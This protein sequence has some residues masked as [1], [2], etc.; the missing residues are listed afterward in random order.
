MELLPVLTICILLNYLS[1][2]HMPQ[3]RERK[4]MSI[5]MPSPYNVKNYPYIEHTKV[6]EMYFSVWKPWIEQCSEKR[7]EKDSQ[8]P[9]KFRHVT[10]GHAE[11]HQ[12]YPE[13]FSPTRRIRHSL[14]RAEPQV[15]ADTEWGGST[16]NDKEQLR[17]KEMWNK[18]K[19]QGMPFNMRECEHCKNS[20]KIPLWKWGSLS[21]TQHSWKIST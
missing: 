12:N 5:T 7:R 16:H 2:S 20:L 4:I 14:W 3:S 6:M 21:D 15:Q 18:S 9:I 11:S 19:T 8:Y 13:D 10:C 17:I 1:G